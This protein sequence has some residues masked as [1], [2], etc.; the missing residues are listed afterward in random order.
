MVDS[1]ELAKGKKERNLPQLDGVVYGYT[2]T[3]NIPF[4]TGKRAGRK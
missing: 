2:K 3:T 4:L 1:N